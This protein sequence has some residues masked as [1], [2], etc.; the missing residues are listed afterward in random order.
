MVRYEAPQWLV[1]G[2][3]EDRAKAWLLEIA[4]Q[5]G[6]DLL[7]V[8]IMVDHVHLLIRLRNGQSLSSCVHRPKGTSA[9]RMFQEMPDLKLDAHTEHFWQKR[10]G[11]KLVPPDAIESVKG[12]IETQKERLEKY[13]RI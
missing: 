12:Y 1:Q 7:A 11:G 3:V 4:A 2:D 9:R 10:F 5:H 13:A 6:I 8:G